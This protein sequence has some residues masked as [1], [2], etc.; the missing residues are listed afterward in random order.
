MTVRNPDNGNHILSNQVTPGPDGSCTTPGA[1][2]TTTPVRSF[3]IVKKADSNTVVPGDT[4]TYTVTVVNDGQVDYT[5]GTP[6]SWSDDLSAVLDDATYNGDVTGGATY[7]APTLSWSGPLAIGATAT[8]TYSVTVNT[9]DTGDQKLT[10]SVVTPPEAGCP[11]G[12][13]NPEC[14]VTIPS[15]SYTVAKS[16]STTMVKPGDTVTYTVTVTNTGNTDYTS[17]APAGFTDDLSSVLDDATYNGDATNGAAVTGTDL[18]WSGP[19]AIGQ[20]LIVTYSVTIDNPDSGDK[21][22]KNTVRA[23]EPGVRATRRGP[24]PRPRRC[25]PSPSRSRPARPELCT[26]ATS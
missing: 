4:I 24:A 2:V 14:T 18:T 7:S 25:R 15:G 9:P 12:S 20:T 10:N 16:A 22:V 26:R 8:F 3:H 5:A 6:A 1:C 17:A 19:L 23:T 13:T 21:A 11:P